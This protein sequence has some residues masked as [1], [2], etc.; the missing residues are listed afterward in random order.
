[1][2]D[3]DTYHPFEDGPGMFSTMTRWRR[4]ARLWGQLDPAGQG[5]LG[6]LCSGVVRAE[7]GPIPG[8][9]NPLLAY[10]RDGLSIS[11]TAGAVWVNGFY[12]FNRNWTALPTPGPVDGLV[13]A[14][15]DP[16]AQEVA[17]VWRGGATDPVQDPEGWW[18]VPL[19]YVD[20]G[21]VIH[22]RRTFVPRT[23]PPPGFTVP[24]WV[25]SGL[26][27]PIVLGPPS[28]LELPTGT[29]AVMST[30][31]AV[32]AGRTYRVT[33][34][35]ANMQVMNPL[36]AGFSRCELWVG[37]SARTRRAVT[38]GGFAS[39]GGGNPWNTTGVQRSWSA[40]LTVDFT[41][42]SAAAGIDYIGN[43]QYMRF[44]ANAARIEVED[45]GEP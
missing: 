3:F 22:D 44:P 2:T 25:P 39:S 11:L 14:R 35:V 8:E 13:V 21:G 34:S 20:A 28:Q 41:G 7:Y 17:L 29:F 5:E 16:A 43:G 19:A 32:P 37:D 45:V 1:M 23:G 33:A 36:E 10:Q 30:A 24:T 6:G 15:F 18:E 12:G 38:W 31:L 27:A 42:S 26:L 4:M 9:P 40:Q